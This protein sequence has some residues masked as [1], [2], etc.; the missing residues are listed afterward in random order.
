MGNVGHA[1]ADDSAWGNAAGA[2]SV[3]R[4]HGAWVVDDATRNV[5]VKSQLM[6]DG[7]SSSCCW[8]WAARSWRW[9]RG[10]QGHSAAGKSRHWHLLDGALAGCMLLCD[11][12]PRPSVLLDACSAWTCGAGFKRESAGPSPGLSEPWLLPSERRS[13][14]P[15]LE[16]GKSVSAPPLLVQAELPAC[17]ALH[18]RLA[19]SAVARHEVAAERYAW[20]LL[21]IPC[22]ASIHHEQP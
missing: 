15:P 13:P 4:L 16:T 12:G 8:Q 1:C 21:S 9:H 22:R 5:A 17:C 19:A 18:Q 2:P 11:P 3:H 10:I 14:W 7:V 6:P 20:P